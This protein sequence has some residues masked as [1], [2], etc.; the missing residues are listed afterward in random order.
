VNAQSFTFRVYIPSTVNT[1]SFAIR[2][3]PQ[4]GCDSYINVSYAGNVITQ[5]HINPGFNCMGSSTTRWRECTATAT[6]AQLQN[7]GV[8][9]NSDNDLEIKHEMLGGTILVAPGNYECFTAQLMGRW[10]YMHFDWIGVSC[11]YM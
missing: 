7:A 5:C 4:D 3:A 10:D 8:V 6:K 9:L 2:A 1:I 11:A